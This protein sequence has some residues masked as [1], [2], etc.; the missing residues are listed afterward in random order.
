[1]MVGATFLMISFVYLSLIF[2]KGNDNTRDL[3]VNNI[4][5]PKTSKLK[6]PLNILH[7]SDLHL[8][9]ISITPMDLKKQLN[10][11]EIDMIALTGDFLDRCKTIPKLVPYLKVFQELQPKYGTYAVFGNHDY[12]LSKNHFHQLKETLQQ[13]GV[14]AM[15]NEN[16][17]LTIDGEKIHIIGIDDYSTSRSDIERSYRNIEDGYKLILTHD[18]NIVLDMKEY[19]YDYLLSGHF[20]GGQIHWPK[21]YHLVKM[22]RLVKM[23]MVKGLQE[24]DGKLF[25]ISEGL[26]QT[27]VNI[28]LGSRPE[29]TFH[30]IA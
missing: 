29:I 23:N 9:H 27:G 10:N 13:H 22:G 25:Y 14:I 17:T 7:I 6:K 12:V 24:Y 18:P 26:G 2:K 3:A 21:P 30:E 4:S 19:H 1:M 20:H 8:E 15:Q 11:K 16:K 5:L 28:R